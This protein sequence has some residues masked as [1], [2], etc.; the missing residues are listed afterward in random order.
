MSSPRLG[1]ARLLRAVDRCQW[2][3]V[4]AREQSDA[5]HDELGARC[6]EIVRQ[7]LGDAA[8]RCQVERMLRGES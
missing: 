6:A 8:K 4:A 5:E 3:A 7:A 2:E 1:F